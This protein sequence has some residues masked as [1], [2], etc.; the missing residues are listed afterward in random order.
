MIDRQIGYHAAL[1]CLHVAWEKD[2]IQLKT[3]SRMIYRLVRINRMCIP[4]AEKR[5]RYA[6]TLIF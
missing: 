5:R 4:E 1:E 2:I 6:K 3:Q